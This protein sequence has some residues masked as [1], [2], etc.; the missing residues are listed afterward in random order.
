[1]RRRILFLC[2]LFPLTGC[3]PRTE[4][5]KDQLLAQIDHLLG[6]VNVRRQEVGDA[7]ARAEAGLDR[8]SHGRIEVQVELSRI[9][10]NYASAKGEVAQA[11][12]ALNRLQ[13]LL[14]QKGEVVIAGETYGPAQLEE[15][16]DRA[17]TNRK[18]ALAE[19]DCLSGT[20]DRLEKIVA[21]LHRREREGRDRLDALKSLLA[22]IDA[23]IV[24]LQ[25]I[26]QAGQAD[27]LNFDDLERQVRDL[28][29]QVDAELAYHEEMWKEGDL[30]LIL[31]GLGVR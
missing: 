22:E 7:L 17:A 16:A 15:M 20:K 28:E 10:D 2:F 3:D 24:A 18:K 21:M 29:A 23:K 9:N 14:G 19:A 31:R 4:V 25:A 11:D 30:D 8:L 6:E 5:A 26:Q 12:Q 13:Q 1:M 27:T